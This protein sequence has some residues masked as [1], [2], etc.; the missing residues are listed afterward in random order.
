M[1][2][3]DQLA[4]LDQ[5]TRMLAECT[6]LDEAKGI[7]DKAAAAGVW[8]RKAKLG[9]EAQ[10]HA[11]EIKVRAERKAGELLREVKRGGGGDRRSE[12]FQKP[13]AGRLKSPYAE[14]LKEAGAT[15]QDA[16][17]WQSVADLPEDEFEEHIASTK[18]AGNEIT[19]A[20]MVRKAK[21]HNRQDRRQERMECLA[22]KAGSFEEGKRYPVL[23]ADPPWRY[24]H[25]KTESRAIENQY[26]TMALEDI[27]ALPIADLVTDEAILFMWT[28]GPK[29]EESLQVLNAWG[30]SYRTCAVWD[31]QKIGMGYYFRQQTEH[32]LVGVRG[33]MITPGES[34]R[35][36]SLISAPRGKHS[37]KPKVVHAVIER[38]YPDLPKLEL[39]CRSPRDGWD[40]WGNEI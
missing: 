1:N 24:E 33:S 18:S 3:T 30:F 5:A 37:E 40:S 23:L 28:T 38:M 15:T 36:S 21:A 31:K 26:P 39:F 6:T 19:T 17:R 35:P 16:S 11:A 7:M 10:N 29:L 25:V 34:D 2:M 13:N 20:E 32:I 9:L 22:E 14:T 27:C 8:A 12:G 4:K